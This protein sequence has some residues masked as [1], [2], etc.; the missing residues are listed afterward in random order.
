MFQ[1]ILGQVLA[2]Q[3]LRVQLMPTSLETFN[4][5]REAESLSTPALI[6]LLIP[7]SQQL[8]QSHVNRDLWNAVAPSP[9]IST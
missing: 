3:W 2:F 9:E 6:I 4:F 7:D 5:L 1:G 8:R